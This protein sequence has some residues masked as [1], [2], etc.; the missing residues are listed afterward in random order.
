MELEL[1]QATTIQADQVTLRRDPSRSVA[2]AA[3][4]ACAPWLTPVT[5][6]AIDVDEAPDKA[7]FDCRKVP[8]RLTVM[9]AGDA[10]LCATQGLTALNR[11]RVQ[12]LAVEAFSQGGILTPEDLAFL[13]GMSLE[14]VGEILAYYGDQVAMLP[15]RGGNGV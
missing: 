11:A 5:Y 4:G 8:V 7:R 14:S 10:V 13:L 9:G 12:R 3:P 6:H 1:I 2:S 15:C